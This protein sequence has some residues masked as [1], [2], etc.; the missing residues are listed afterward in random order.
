MIS[1]EALAEIERIGHLR[2]PAEA[3]GVLLPVPDGA[4]TVVELP[5]RSQRAH[6]SYMFT[7]DDVVM[8]LKDWLVEQSDE[9][10]SG[11]IVWHTHPK[12]NIGPSRT[13]LQGKQQ[14]VTYAVVAL[15]PS[16]PVAAMF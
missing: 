9:V 11:I 5:N 16:G 2:A 8:E 3:C 7:T 6:D 13:D 15:T 12:G 14:G 4:R 1:D 10:R